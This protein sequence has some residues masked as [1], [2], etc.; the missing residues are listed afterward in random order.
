MFTHIFFYSGHEL[1]ELMHQ[2]D[3]IV[4]QYEE[5][6]SFVR[7]YLTD[8]HFRQNYIHYKRSQ[9]SYERLFYLEEQMIYFINSFQHVSSMFLTD[10]VGP[11]WLQTYFMRKFRDVQFR[12]SFLERSL[13]TQTFWPQRPINNKTSPIIVKKRNLTGNSFLQTF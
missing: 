12:L 11:E 7:L 4:R 2:Y 10:D 5:T 6:M 9:E 3:G 13:K 8:I 1:Y